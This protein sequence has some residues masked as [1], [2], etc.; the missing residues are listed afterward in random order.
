[1]YREGH[2]NHPSPHWT[3]DIPG[4]APA[5]VEGQTVVDAALDW[6]STEAQPRVRD[7]RTQLPVNA[8]DRFGTP[9]PT[10]SRQPFSM[11]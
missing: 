8:Q 2:A 10:V 9:A 11:E 6:R 3:H 1:M 5:V 4:W 7:V